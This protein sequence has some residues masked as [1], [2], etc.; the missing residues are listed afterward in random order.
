MAAPGPGWLEALKPPPSQPPSKIS[1]TSVIQVI[2]II[3]QIMHSY[4]VYVPLCD[5]CLPPKL[6]PVLAPWLVGSDGGEKLR[7]Y[8]S[9]AE[10][11]LSGDLVS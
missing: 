8:Q 11:C 5:V 1:H 4:F 10:L 3:R 2:L 7:F 6:G 9:L